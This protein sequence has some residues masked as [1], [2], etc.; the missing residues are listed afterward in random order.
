MGGIR[1]MIARGVLALVDSSPKLQAL[2]ARITAGEV[3]G[4]LEHFESYGFT[5]NPK[6]GAEMLVAFLGGDR[7]HGAVF[8]VADRR[9]RLQGLE[10]GEVALYS[11]EGDSVVLRRGRV[12]EVTTEVFRLNAKRCELN[13]AEEISLN[14]PLVSAP[15][16]LDVD[17]EVRAGPVSVRG[18]VHKG[19]QPGNGTSGEAV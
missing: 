3:K 2:Q 7:S 4:G 17:G 14:T 1:G 15:G 19:V 16:D 9:Y 10:S 11:D 5:S 8:C 12:V 13:V 18:H 6:P